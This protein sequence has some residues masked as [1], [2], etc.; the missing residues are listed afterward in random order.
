[1]DSTQGERTLWI[2]TP[3]ESPRQTPECTSNQKTDSLMFQDLC[4]TR[5]GVVDDGRTRQ[6]ITSPGRADYRPTDRSGNPGNRENSRPLPR[7]LAAIP[8]CAGHI[9]LISAAA[10][11]SHQPGSRRSQ[12]NSRSYARGC[13]RNRAMNTCSLLPQPMGT[14]TAA[15]SPGRET[16]SAGVCQPGYTTLCNAS[17]EAGI[18][19]RQNTTP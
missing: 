10:R 15:A 1:M 11:L 6:P 14:K 13:V 2:Q 16:A 7:A 19:Q 12:I 18:V 5:T 8:G 3:A 17:L 9:Q 4:T